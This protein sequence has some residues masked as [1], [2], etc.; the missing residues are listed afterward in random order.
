MSIFFPIL[1]GLKDSWI[2]KAKNSSKV[3]HVHSMCKSDMF[4]HMNKHEGWKIG[5]KFI[6]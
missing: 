5:V 2:F 4:E 3:N 6:V 1:I